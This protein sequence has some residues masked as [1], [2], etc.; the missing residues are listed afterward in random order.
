MKG[1][2]VPEGGGHEFTPVK[3]VPAPIRAVMREELRRVRVFRGRGGFEAAVPQDVIERMYEFARR[4]V[5]NECMGK[6][7]TVVGEDEQGV[8]VLIVGAVLDEG[9][10]GTPAFIET[11]G[12]SDFVTCRT[13][14]RLY[15]GATA[16]G[17]FH[18]HVRIGAT[19]SGTDR[20]SQSSW[21]LASALGIVVDPWSAPHVAVYR[22]PEAELLTEVTAQASS[23]GPAGGLVPDVPGPTPSSTSS[24]KAAALATA[25]TPAP[26]ARRARLLPLALVLISLTSTALG[27]LA[28]RRE[29]MPPPVI[30]IE[31]IHIPSNEKSSPASPAAMPVEDFN[32]P[33][34]LPIP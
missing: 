1:S 23:P 29:R 10:V 20:K 27:A 3:V 4:A 11:S 34:D 22:G 21:K 6:L 28:L 9:A 15:A 33:L 18:S 2:A 24:A 19:Y 13:L 14:D 30:R 8:H 26:K 31:V 17:W 25:V 7:A 12:A 32:V 16:G 5:P